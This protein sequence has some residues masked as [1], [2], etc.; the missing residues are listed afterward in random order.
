MGNKVFN[1]PGNDLDEEDLSELTKLKEPDPEDHIGEHV[2]RSSDIE[3]IALKEDKID[4]SISTSPELI[5][6]NDGIRVS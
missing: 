2:Y 6:Q 3:D 5:K 4:R 1:F